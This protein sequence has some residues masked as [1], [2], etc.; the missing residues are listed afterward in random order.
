[1]V[2][3]HAP[4]GEEDNIV[5][6][7]VNHIK[8]KKWKRRP[9]IFHGGIYKNNIM[10][11]FGKPKVAVF[12][13]IDSVGFMIGHEKTLLEIGG[14]NYSKG[15]KLKGYDNEG[16]VNVTIKT[17]RKKKK[18][19]GKIRYASKRPVELGTNL[20]YVPKWTETSKTIQ[21]PFLDNRLG[22]YIALKVSDTLENGILV[23]TASEE[24]G[25]GDV[26]FLSKLIYERY[27]VKQA[28]ICDIMPCSKEVKLGGG[29]AVS[30]R[31]RNIP[32]RS[33]VN[34]IIDLVKKSDHHYQFEAQDKGGNDGG[35]L[36]MSSTPFDWCQIGV[37]IAKYH[38]PRERADKSD[39]ANAI[40]LYKYLLKRIK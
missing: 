32:R 8:K 4:S 20:T 19:K 40:K 14:P 35:D 7:I 21:T 11:V 17:N 18:K 25:G 34:K 2:E 1:M 29:V 9:K 30:F 5:D 10:L 31:D 26:Q 36:I 3:I 12:S 15:D 16:L 39:I 13:H 6:Y 22:T 37:P 23:F 24:T 38:S 33:Y 27:N 28:L